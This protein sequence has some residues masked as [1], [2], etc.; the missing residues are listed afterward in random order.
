VQM[1]M[2]HE[3]AHCMQMN[4]SGAFWK[5]RNQYAEELRGLWANGYTGMGSGAGERLC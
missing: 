1:V 3:L 2:M 4:H 5:V